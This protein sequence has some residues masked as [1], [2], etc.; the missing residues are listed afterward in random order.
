MLATDKQ[1]SDEQSRQVAATI[2]E[3]LAR[4]RISRQHLAEQAKIS[5]STLEKALVRPPAVHACDDGAA[6]G[7]ARRVAAQGGPTAP[8]PPRPLTALAPDELGSYSRRAV[9]VDRGQLPDAAAVVRRPGAIY[10]YRTEICWD[11]KQP[12]C[13]IFRESE[14]LD[15]ASPSSARCRC[16]TSRATS[17]SSPTGT[18]STG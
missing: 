5:I 9:S 14:R 7:G 6:G 12:R 2:R 8:A 3:E 17:I 10:A 1:L 18:V 15:A 13:L 11:A 16:R 4:R